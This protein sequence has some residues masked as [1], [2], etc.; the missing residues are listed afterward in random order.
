LRLPIADLNAM[1]VRVNDGEDSPE[2][3]EAVARDWIAANQAD[4]DALI[5]EAKAAN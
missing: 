5:N 1:M 2:Q 4:F 3:I